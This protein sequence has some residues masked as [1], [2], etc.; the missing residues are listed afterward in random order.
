MKTKSRD[1][2]LGVRVTLPSPQATHAAPLRN[3]ANGGGLAESFAAVPAASKKTGMR[4]AHPTKKKKELERLRGITLTDAGGCAAGRSCA[5]RSARPSSPRRPRRRRTPAPGR[6][7]LSQ[8]AGRSSRGRRAFAA[9]RERRPREWSRRWPGTRGRG[10]PGLKDSVAERSNHSNLCR[11]EFGS[12][13]VRI[14]EN[15]TEFFRNFETI[16]L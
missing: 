2:I 7:A 3:F 8:A 15:S 14:Q 6:A 10:E 13:S 11:S 9:H 1:L 4:R 5:A 12:N 16:S